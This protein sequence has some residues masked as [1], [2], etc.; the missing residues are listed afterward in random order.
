[1]SGVKLIRIQTS[2]SGIVARCYAIYGQ[3]R[4]MATV[5][6]LA[7]KTTRGEDE[8]CCNIERLHSTSS[9]GRWVVSYTQTHNMVDDFCLEVNRVGESSNGRG[10]LVNVD[11]LHTSCSKLASTLDVAQ[12]HFTY[13][14]SRSNI[15]NKALW[16]H[17]LSTLINQYLPWETTCL[18]P[19]CPP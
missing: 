18:A 14:C 4:G 15:L 12:H 2:E 13:V 10:E 19:G 5:W 9:C 17:T 1:M 16:H 7:S 6:V 8:Q 11:A 3:V